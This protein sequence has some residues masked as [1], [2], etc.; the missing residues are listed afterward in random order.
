MAPVWYSLSTAISRLGEGVWAAEKTWANTRRATQN[1]DR[2][3]VV[4]VLFISPPSCRF[5]QL[6]EG[7]LNLTGDIARPLPHFNHSLE[8]NV[9]T[10]SSGIS[11]GLFRT[12]LELHNEVMSLPLSPRNS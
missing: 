10:A 8:T 1:K 9:F 6:R 11:I 5:G 2:A 3:N 12:T 7:Q 4:R